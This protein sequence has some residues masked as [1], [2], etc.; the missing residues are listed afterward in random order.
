MVS[1]IHKGL[2]ANYVFKVKRKAIK[3][4]I[5]VN[6]LFNILTLFLS[7][8]CLNI[9]DLIPY[10]LIYHFVIYISLLENRLITTWQSLYRIRLALS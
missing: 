10:S 3:L 2:C 6:F 9:L 4:H 8:M 7:F 5:S 1:S